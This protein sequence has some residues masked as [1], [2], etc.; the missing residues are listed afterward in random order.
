VSAAVAL[1]LMAGWGLWRTYRRNRMRVQ[2]RA[3]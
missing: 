3:K 1:T 2:N